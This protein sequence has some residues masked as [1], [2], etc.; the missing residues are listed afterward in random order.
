[1]AESLPSPPPVW[2][3]LLELTHD[4]AR[5]VAVVFQLA[6]DQGREQRVTLELTFLD[7]STVAVALAP[8]SDNSDGKGAVAGDAAGPCEGAACVDSEPMQ[9]M[10]PTQ[11]LEQQHEQLLQENVRLEALVRQVRVSASGQVWPCAVHVSSLPFKPTLLHCCPPP[12][13]A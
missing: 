10:Q 8:C 13:A 11:T 3:L 6:E 1:M 5:P 4:D 7:D 2:L 9:P 12:N